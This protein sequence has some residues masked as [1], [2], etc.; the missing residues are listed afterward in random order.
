MKDPVEMSLL[1]D[2]YGAVLTAKQADVY[3]MYHNADLS[4]AE[5]A[6]NAG[7]TRQGV[8]DMLTRAEHT[9]FSL[10]EKLGYVGRFRMQRDNAQRVLSWLDELDTLNARAL[11]SDIL[12]QRLKQISASVREMVGE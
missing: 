5:I 6:E 2:H 11:S 4:L 12:A 9:L 7:I 10:E 1:F 8:H 3:E